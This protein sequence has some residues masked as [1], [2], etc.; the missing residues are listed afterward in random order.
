MPANDISTY[1][2]LLL[3]SQK[4]RRLLVALNVPCLFLSIY[5]GIGIQFGTHPARDSWVLTV[6]LAIVLVLP[7]VTAM[8]WLSGLRTAMN[9]TLASNALALA[10]VLAIFVAVPASNGKAVDLFIWALFALTLSG[11]FVLGSAFFRE[12]RSDVQC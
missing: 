5:F 7:F 4:A 10:L 9:L 3:L 8:L 6:P 2:N 1:A 12:K 11:N